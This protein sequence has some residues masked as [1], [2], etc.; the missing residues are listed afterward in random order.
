[1]SELIEKK[2]A[3]YI[4]DVDSPL[5]A[6]GGGS[7][8]S[9]SGA[10]G[11]SL[12]RMAA[13][14]SFEK[15]KFKEASKTKQNKFILAFKEIEYYKGLLVKGVDDDA[16]SY[17]AV[18]QAYRSKDES[19]IQ[20][21]LLSSA[22]TAFEMQEAS[23]KALEFVEK[24]IE[25]ANKNLYSD[26]ISGAILLASC[27]EMASLNVKANAMLLKDKQVQEFYLN[28]SKQLVLKSK[29]KKNKI[30]NIINKL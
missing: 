24:L 22:M 20:S 10:L 16:V 9:L 23:L 12:A 14:L 27:N 19:Q 25:L 3:E 4:N 1:M 2:V 13:H 17:N 5:P 8:A 11:A 21:A 28:S 30:I 26:I 29:S 7:V 15:K 18:I 6:P